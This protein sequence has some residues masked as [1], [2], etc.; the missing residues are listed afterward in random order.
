MTTEKQENAIHNNQ[1]MP[2][3]YVT[4]ICYSICQ[5]DIGIL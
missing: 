3:M 2:I 5:S 4:L 1:N